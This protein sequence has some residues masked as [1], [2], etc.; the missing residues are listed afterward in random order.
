VRSVLVHCPSIIEY[1]ARS[2]PASLHLDVVASG[3]IDARRMVVDVARAL[4]QAG[5]D[6]ID[7]TV[8]PVER[9][10]RDPLTGKL[11]SF[12]VDTATGAT[13]A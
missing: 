4:S 10:A 3:P 5:A 13:S 11:F 7:V 2:G 6:A 1:Q 9:L 8:T 12:V